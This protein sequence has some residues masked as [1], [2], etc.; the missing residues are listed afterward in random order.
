MSQVFVG[1]LQQFPFDWAP[2]GW[3][4]C[5]GALIST[6]QYQAL[7]ALIGTTYGG[8]GTTNFAI[9]D[10][11]GRTLVGQGQF[12][13]GGRYTMG[14]ASGSESYVLT[15]QNLPIHNHVL[16]ASPQAA[17]AATP[18]GASPY[19]AHSNGSDPTSGDAVTV[20][21]YAPVGAAQPLQG[22]TTAGGNQ[23][24]DLMQPYI[25]NNYCIAVEGIYPS[26]N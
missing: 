22:V 12:P 17:N 11:R 18:G 1:Q 16:F 13:G 21:I 8:N 25:V 3:M 24:I 4:I 14:E 5:N 10:I 26:R 7:F 2:R 6:V 19:L 15:Q 20:Q 9:P 23:P